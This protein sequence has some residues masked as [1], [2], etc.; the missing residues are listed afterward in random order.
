M[1]QNDNAA[2]GTTDSRL[3]FDISANETYFIRV[4]GQNG[5]RGEYEL[6]IDSL[7]SGGLEPT[8]D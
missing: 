1:A 8:R 4:R 5:T 2:R 7:L 6:A 3:T